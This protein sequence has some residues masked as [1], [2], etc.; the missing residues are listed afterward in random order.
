MPSTISIPPEAI[1]NTA[2]PTATHHICAKI[3]YTKTAFSGARSN[4]S[5]SARLP[6]NFSG[7]EHDGQLQR[8]GHPNGAHQAPM[9]PLFPQCGHERR[10][11]GIAGPFR[12]GIMVGAAMG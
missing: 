5:T 1:P 6:L 2:A 3:A 9:I 8:M 12:G 4:A 10:V 11:R 7:R